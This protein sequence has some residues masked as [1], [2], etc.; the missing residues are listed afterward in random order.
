MYRSDE[1]VYPL[2]VEGLA[3]LSDYLEVPVDPLADNGRAYYYASTGQTYSLCA[4]LE[5]ETTSANC[6]GDCGDQI[7]SYK[8]VN[9]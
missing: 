6:S 3:A 5:G 9:P 8:V 4:A 2:T 1:G 7:C